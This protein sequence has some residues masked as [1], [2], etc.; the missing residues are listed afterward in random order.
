MS[1]KRPRRFNA[2]YKGGYVINE[3]SVCTHTH[4][5]KVKAR[6][7]SPIIFQDCLSKDQRDRTLDKI[8]LK[9]GNENRLGLLSRKDFKIDR[10]TNVYTLDIYY[11]V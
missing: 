1:A 8:I 10:Y 2:S 7:M 3:K 11:N 6:A 5:S 4:A 9:E